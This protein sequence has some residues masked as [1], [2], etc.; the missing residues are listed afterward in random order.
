MK[1]TRR[2]LSFV[3]ALVMILPMLAVMTVAEETNVVWAGDNFDSESWD[4]L[5]S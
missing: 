3:L 4:N 2:I 5:Y 1:R